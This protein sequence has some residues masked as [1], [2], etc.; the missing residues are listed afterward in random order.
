MGRQRRLLRPQI[1]HTIRANMIYLYMWGS[2]LGAVTAVYL[3]EQTQS[4][5]TIL[6]RIVPTLSVSLLLTA[7]MI[8]LWT[9]KFAAQSLVSRWV[10]VYQNCWTAFN[11]LSSDNWRITMQWLRQLS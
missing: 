10:P 7:L 11:A 8:Q 1:L 5:G 6:L 3:Y 2:A 4:D 9:I